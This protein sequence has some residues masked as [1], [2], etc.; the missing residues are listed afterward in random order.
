MHTVLPLVGYDGGSDVLDLSELAALAADH[1]HD[2]FDHYR[3]ILELPRYVS[4]DL[5]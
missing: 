2:D 3:E 5:G 1:A 4:L